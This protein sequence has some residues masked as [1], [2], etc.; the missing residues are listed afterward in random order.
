MKRN[1]LSFALLLFCFVS[2]GQTWEALNDSPYSGHHAIN[3]SIDGVGYSVTG[4]IVSSIINP[5]GS[6]S[7]Q[8]YSYDPDLDEWTQLADYPG[9][10]RG[11][12]IGDVW[13]GK[14]YIGFG[15]NGNDTPLRDL[16]SY[17][18]ATDTWTELASCP[19]TPRFHP[20]F[21]A[22]NGKIFMGMGGSDNG[23][24]NDWWEYD[25]AADTWQQR[26]SFPSLV[27]HHPYQFAIGDYVYTGL[28]HGNGPGLNIYQD[29]YRYDPAN[30]QWTQVASIPAEGRVA[31][32]Q[33]S[34]NGKGYVLSGDGDDHSYMDTGEFWE[35]DPVADTWTELPPH[36]GTSRWAPSSFII[37]DY[38]YFMT[39]LSQ[40]LVEDAYVWRYL[41]ESTPT[42]TTDLDE[43]ALRIFPNPSS[44]VITIALENANATIQG[45]SIFNLKGQLLQMYPAT[46][47]NLTTINIQDLPIGIYQLKVN[48]ED[49]VLVQKIVRQ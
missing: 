43:Q 44:D 40:S 16:W 29:W 4:N 45:I 25:I 35:Y 3:F 14:A 42:S 32:T 6:P 2:N 19:C 23:N 15:L 22:L 28:G 47:N 17:D 48:L 33:F 12:G 38:V 26:P 37:D 46:Y 41:M 30:N 11:Y 9:S 20:A 27:R 8:F 49:E 13:E 10:N 39:G 36:P 21:V 24:L 5:F 7:K 31:G 18:P 1:L 34:H